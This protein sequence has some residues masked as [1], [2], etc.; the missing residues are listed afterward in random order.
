M[1]TAHVVRRLGVLL[2]T[3]VSATACAQFGTSDAALPTAPSAVL[4]ETPSGA[5]TIRTMVAPW[6]PYDAT[7]SWHLVAT[8]PN[9]T[10]LDEGDVDL[11]QH[12]DGTITFSDD[13]SVF[14]F[15][16]RGGGPRRTIALRLSVYGPIVL[17]NSPCETKISGTAFL[18]TQTDT[19]E[20]TRFSGVEDDCAEVSGTATLTRN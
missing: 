3:T 9:G 1:V 17:P 15:T 19:I 13:V 16:S 8:A 2:L 4:S 7:G 14:T 10:I 12:S 11:T 5:G 18:D 6:L 20:V